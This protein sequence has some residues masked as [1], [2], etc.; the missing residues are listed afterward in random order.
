MII[1]ADAKKAFNKTQ[2]LFVIKKKKKLQKISIEWNYLNI[3]KSIY[4]KA[5]DSII[6][7]SENLKGISS[8]IISK[9]SVASLTT[10]IQYG[11]G[12]LSQS[13]QRRKRK[14]IEMEKVLN[15]S[16]LAGDRIL[17]IEK[18]EDNS[19]QLLELIN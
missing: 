11:F 13:N 18:P 4:N 1:S 19:G 16:L 12:I 14:G 10:V 2:H 6:P 3:I 8:K 5:T 7:N 9:A 15:L 17:Y